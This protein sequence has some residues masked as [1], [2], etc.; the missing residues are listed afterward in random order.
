MIDCS[1]TS[2]GRRERHRYRPKK[3]S[4]GRIGVGRQWEENTPA[5]VLVLSE[6]RRIKNRPLTWQEVLAILKKSPPKDIPPLR[7]RE[8]LQANGLIRSIGDGTW[9]IIPPTS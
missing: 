3:K 2:A 9:E 1:A 8:I 6:A 5:A 7:K 4:S